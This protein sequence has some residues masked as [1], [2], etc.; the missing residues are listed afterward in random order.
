MAALTRQE[1]EGRPDA[2]LDRLTEPTR[3]CSSPGCTRPVYAGHLC[4][5]HRDTT[6]YAQGCPP[7]PPPNRRRAI[8]PH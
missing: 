2:T 5:L 8:P 1:W 3:L 7:L 6:W 4:K